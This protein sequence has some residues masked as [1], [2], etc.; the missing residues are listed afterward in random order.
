MNRFVTK[1]LA[2]TATINADNI[3]TLLL[4]PE[5][6]STAGILWKIIIQ[7]MGSDMFHGVRL[8]FR[9][10]QIKNSV[11]RRGLFYDTTSR[12]LCIVTSLK[13][14]NDNKM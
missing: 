13:R 11:F 4:Q 8:C 5:Q 2:N 3:Q 14:K 7:F 6:V 10:P 9:F 12:N 1:H